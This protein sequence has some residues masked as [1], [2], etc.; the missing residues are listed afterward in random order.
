MRNVIRIF[1]WL[2]LTV[3]GLAQPFRPWLNAG[4]SDPRNLGNLAAWYDLSNTTSFVKDG[5]NR[6]QLISDVSG[7]STTNCLCL[8]G[9]AGN[10]ASFTALTAFGTGDFTVSVKAML[11]VFTNNPR[12]IS[13]NINAFGFGCDTSG[14]PTAGQ[15]GVSA[16]TS[17][18]TLVVLTPVVVTYTRSGTT[19]T[20][21]INGVLSDTVSDS[22]NYSVGLTLIGATVVGSNNNLTGNI[23]W[24]RV[25]SVALTAPQVAADAAGTVQANCVFNAD[26]SVVAKLATSFTES[27][28]NAATVTIN[29]SGDLG[30]RIS[31]ERDLVQMTAS[32]QPIYSVVNGRGLI[33]FDGTDDYMKA[34][35]FSLSQPET[36]YFVGSQVTW[37]SGDRIIDGNLV[38][39]GGVYQITSTPNLVIRAGTQV[40]DNTEFTL[41]TPGV[42]TVGF[43]GASSFLRVNLGTPTTGNAGASNM[44]GLT[45]A[46][47]GTGSSGNNGNITTSEI[48]IYSAAQTTA[49]QNSVIEYA[50]LKWGL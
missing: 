39:T 38:N 42:L 13:G 11:S 49:Q 28:S 30:A 32:K 43:N 35:A 16:L 47:T 2:T 27:S 34:A 18:A 1:F 8:N 26:M 48:A 22:L 46:E 4:V 19:G 36:I 37:T 9:V 23:Y 29:T 33:T 41:N 15:I 45:L 44:G 7:N 40:A 12:I 14:H 31:G 17:T 50:I 10:Y 6:V 25:Y 3:A 5:S 21:Y 20:F 24:S